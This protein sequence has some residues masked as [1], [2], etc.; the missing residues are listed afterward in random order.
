M[1]YI[2]LYFYPHFFSIALTGHI[3]VAPYYVMDG[4]NVPV[5]TLKVLPDI[6]L[7]SL[8]EMRAYCV[9]IAGTSN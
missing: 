4:E 2:Y 5:A 8:A 9:C 1:I 3:A 7:A 6:S